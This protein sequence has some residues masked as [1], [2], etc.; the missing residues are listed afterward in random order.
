MEI[1][2]TI[3]PA[4]FHTIAQMA[5]TGTSPT[6]R[7]S[8]NATAPAEFYVV[9]AGGACT[10]NFVF[11]HPVRFADTPLPQGERGEIIRLFI[12]LHVQRYSNSQG[13]NYDPK[14]AAS[15]DALDAPKTH[16]KYSIDDAWMKRGRRA[17]IDTA[18]NARNPRVPRRCLAW[19]VDLNQLFAT[20]S[21]QLHN[22]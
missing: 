17:F 13:L 10:Y 14:H 2:Y 8:T 20:L 3:D 1:E 6:A 19:A 22:H 7:R 16:L 21:Q 9:I 12:P 11:P 15:S 18:T 4:L 5:S